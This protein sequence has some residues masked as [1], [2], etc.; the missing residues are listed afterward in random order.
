MARS[1]EDRLADSLSIL[2]IEETKTRTTRGGSNKNPSIIIIPVGIAGSRKARLLDGFSAYASNSGMTF[3]Q[4]NYKDLSKL[5]KEKFLSKFG[6]N[7]FGAESGE[8]DSRIYNLM[9]A[10]T[11]T[12]FFTIVAEAINARPTGHIV[13]LRRNHPPNSV[14]ATINKIRSGLHGPEPIF[15]AVSAE[16]KAPIIINAKTQFP[17]SY[18]FIFDCMKVWKGRLT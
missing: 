12:K 10:E 15:L 13:L 3:E 14:K 16:C 2:S 1:V 11:K 8:V 7:A 17:I 6:D 9:Q 5:F 18:N 4:V